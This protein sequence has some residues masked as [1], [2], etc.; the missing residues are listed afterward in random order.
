MSIPQSF[1]IIIIGNNPSMSQSLTLDRID[2]FKHYI[3]S[4]T[5]IWKNI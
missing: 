5:Y 3:R 2:K 4:K 1:Y